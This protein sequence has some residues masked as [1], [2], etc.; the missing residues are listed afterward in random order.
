[1]SVSGSQAGKGTCDG[2]AY[3]VQ[4]PAEF[5]SALPGI[6]ILSS[7]QGESRGD[8]GLCR[9]HERM[10]SSAMTCGDF[11]LRAGGE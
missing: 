3:L 8:Q 11:Q 10:V 5:E 9:V 2:C 1:M 6:L 7:G 4:D